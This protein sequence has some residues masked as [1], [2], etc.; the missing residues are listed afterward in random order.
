MKSLVGA[1]LGFGA[2][3]F[4]VGVGSTI[5]KSNEPGFTTLHTCETPVEIKKP[6]SKSGKPTAAKTEGTVV[7]IKQQNF[8]PA[9]NVEATETVRGYEYTKGQFAVFTDEELDAIKPPDTKEIIV[10]KF[11]ASNSVTGQMVADQYYLIPDTSSAHGA[12]TYSILYR[13]L[14]RAKLAA[15]GSEWLF[16]RKEHPCAVVADHSHKGHPVLMLQVLHVADDLI[17]PDF[18]ADVLGTDKTTKDEIIMAETLVGMMMGDLMPEDLVSG[19]RKR[20]EA[21]IAARIEESALPVFAHAKPG[22]PADLMAALRES[23]EMQKA[24]A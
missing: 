7:P 18:G 19:Q 10:S 5:A 11:V 22:E 13:V 24:G 2:V 20:K 14:T 6:D 9:C 15:I 16:Q 3:S 12:H 21:L 1:T 23:I 8:C 17:T 4:R